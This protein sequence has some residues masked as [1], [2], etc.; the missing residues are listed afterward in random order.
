MRP[1]DLKLLSIVRVRHEAS[2]QV[3]IVYRIHGEPE[4]YDL[5]LGPY[6]AEQLAMT[7]L[8]KRYADFLRDMEHRGR[9]RSG[10]DD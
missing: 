3:V 6:E 5:V 4:E 8:P 1:D 10:E 2:G 7:L 9:A